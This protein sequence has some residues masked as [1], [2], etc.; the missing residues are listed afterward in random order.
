[1]SYSLKAALSILVGI[2]AVVAVLAVGNGTADVVGAVIVTGAIVVF[3]RAVLSLASESGEP[4]P[5][6]EKAP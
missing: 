2:A 3:M 6:S 5:P 1:M 4:P